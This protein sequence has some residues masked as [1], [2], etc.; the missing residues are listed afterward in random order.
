MCNYAFS[1]D[2]WSS[3]RAFIL[4]LAL[5]W[6]EFSLQ[7]FLKNTICKTLKTNCVLT[8]TFSDIC[9]AHR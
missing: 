4:P 5:A 9:R 3:D 7:S 6:A 2:I 1:H 8:K